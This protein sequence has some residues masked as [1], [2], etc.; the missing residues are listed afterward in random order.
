MS[1]KF[2]PMQQLH[3]KTSLAILTLFGTPKRYNFQAIGADIDNIFLFNYFKCF[4]VNP[5]TTQNTP[6]E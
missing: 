5:K 1:L 4:A 6:K 2:E 3:S